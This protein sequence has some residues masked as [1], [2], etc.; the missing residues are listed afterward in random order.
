[1]AKS[2]AISLIVNN[3]IVEI[4]QLYTAVDESYCNLYNSI[5]YSDVTYN[6]Y[7]SIKM[8][9][10]Y[11]DC[12]VHPTKKTVNIINCSIFCKQLT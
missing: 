12:N 6:V 9:P 5:H 4:P 2:K 1:M 10:K 11:I 8:D 7:L 3:R